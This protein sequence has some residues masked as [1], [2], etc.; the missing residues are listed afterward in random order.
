[1]KKFVRGYLP[2][3]LGLVVGAYLSLPKVAWAAG[4]SGESLGSI[5][6]MWSVIPFVGI[7]LSIALGPLLNFHWWEHNMGKVSLFW[8]LLFLLP[9]ALGYGF[10]TAVYNILH[11]YVIDYIPFIILLAGLFVISGGIIVRGSLQATPKHNMAMLLIGSI[12]ASCI[13]T[14]GASMVLIRPLIRANLCRTHKLHTIVFFIFLVSNIGGSLTPIGDPPLFLGFLHGVPFFWT[15]ALL[16]MFIINVAALLIV[17]W[18][19]DSYFYKKEQESPS[20]AA[21]Q[22]D[23]KEPVRI[24]G[25]VNLVFLFGVITAVIM[26]GLLTKSPAFFNEQTQTL[27]GIPLFTGH[28]HTLELAWINLT[29]DSIIILMAVFSWFATPLALRKENHFT[30]GP[31]KEVAI[32][33]AGIF[34]T[35]IPA[36]AILQARGGELGV[37][38]AAQFF[39]ATGMLSSFLDN[40]PTY[41]AFLSL[42]GG[43]GLQSGVW[44]DLGF[45]NPHVLQAISAGA[46]FMGAN[47]YIGNAPNFMVRSIAEE[48]QIKMPSF[49]GYMAWSACILLPLFL[50]NTWLF[51]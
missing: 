3:S 42:A 33:F 45:V 43:L 46:V 51:F 36:I 48:N 19:L 22:E 35:I 4:G 12:L 16:P 2:A 20:V 50:L 8:G 11:M 21:A 37:S 9:F 41:L 7:L 10:E 39:W 40:A 47:T 5:L 17:Y 28:G 13:G 25:L 18:L 24:G 6:P 14:T 30:W 49:F 27:R 32:L 15:L 23:C 26:S 38:S 1:M 34:A 31:I 44:T 29:R